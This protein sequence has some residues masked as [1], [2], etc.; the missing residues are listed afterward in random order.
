MDGLGCVTIWSSV[1]VQRPRRANKKQ[2]AGLLKVRREGE[3]YA[4]RFPFRSPSAG[5]V[6]F[7]HRHSLRF[8]AEVFRRDDMKRKAII[9]SSWIFFGSHALLFILVVAVLALIKAS[10]Y[11]GYCYA[12]PGDAESIDKC[13]LSEYLL[14]KPLEYILI[15]IL[16]CF[17]FTPLTAVAA[18]IVFLIY[19]SKNEMA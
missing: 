3:L 17:T 11:D 13:T 6:F 5:K 1:S 7:R 10:A 16:S 4:G 9:Y 8:L 14:D 12:I 15:Y 2:L 19:I 18:L